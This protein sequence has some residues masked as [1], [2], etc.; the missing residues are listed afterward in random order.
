M[1]GNPVC[2]LREDGV[3]G[4]AVARMMNALGYD[5]GVIGNHEFDI[6]Y[7][8]LRAAGGPARTTRVLAADLRLADGR[9]AFAAGPLVLERGRAEDRHH[10]RLLRRHDG[11]GDPRAAGPGD[12]G[13]TRTP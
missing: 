2:R 4:A 6:G 7:P 11:R 10:R 13:A 12:A 3:P 1:T 5:A 8:D 9:R